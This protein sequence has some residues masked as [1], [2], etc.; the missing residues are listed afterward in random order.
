MVL[1]EEALRAQVP[2][3]V[4]DVKGDLP[5]LLLSFPTLSPSELMPWVSAAASANDT[6]AP[7]A[8]AEELAEQRSSGLAACRSHDEASPEA[9]EE[10]LD[11]SRRFSRR[12]LCRCILLGA[13]CNGSAC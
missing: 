11:N 9:S 2:V 6:R 4:I 3:L 5:N 7:A 8:I 1:V 13:R 12:R 10:V